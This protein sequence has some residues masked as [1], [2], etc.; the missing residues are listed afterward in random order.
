MCIYDYMT[1]YI[2]C[3]QS[4][5]HFRVMNVMFDFVIINIYFLT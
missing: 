2:M 3:M 4:R 5:M 1:I